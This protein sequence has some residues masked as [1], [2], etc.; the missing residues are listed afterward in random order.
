MEHHD[1]I[2]SVNRSLELSPRG[3]APV[4]SAGPSRRYNPETDEPP[5]EIT[6]HNLILRHNGDCYTYPECMAGVPLIKIDETHP[7]WEPTW[8]DV[9]AE[10]TAAR[11]RWAEK[12]MAVVEAEARQEK[13][14]SSRYQIGRQ[15]NR[16]DK[17]LEYLDKGDISPYQLLGKRFMHVSKGGI[18]SYD[19]LFRLVE[20][21]GELEKFKL[22]I[23][24]VEWMRHRLWE[25]MQAEGSEF[26]FHRTVHDFYHDPKLT[27]LRFKHGFKNIGRP[28]GAHKTGRPSLGSENGTPKPLKKRK[29]GYLDNGTPGS[30]TFIE[31]SP[32]SSNMS[33]PPENVYEHPHKRLR[34]SYD[35][36]SDSYPPPEL[37]QHAPMDLFASDG[38]SD[39]DSVTGAAVTAVDFALQQVKTRDFTS[40]TKHQ[41]Y[42]TFTREMS[43]FEHHFSIKSDPAEWATYPEPIDF[44][45]RMEEISEVIWN[46]EAQMVQIKVNPDRYAVRSA[47]DNEPRGDLMATFKRVRTMKRFLS[48]CRERG[49]AM[50]RES[51]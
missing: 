36:F 6:R 30:V 23:T 45:F 11:Q 24:P 17:I 12:R 1:F 21:L 43:A 26:S 40:S 2:S 14:G 4:P 22:D 28:S 39:T 27:H 16:G 10:V 31:Q 38:H 7:Y 5:E 9:K 29:S 34:E 42:W 19:T 32:L 3:T 18:T 15:V 44:N 41:Q 35:S 46:L 37:N 47:K 33:Y 48:L 51:P 13:T 8:K 20:T 49:M 25:I 50:V